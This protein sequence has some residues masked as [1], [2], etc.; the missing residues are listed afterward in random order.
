MVTWSGRG[1]TLEWLDFIRESNLTSRAGHLRGCAEAE[2]NL[3]GADKTCDFVT[4]VHNLREHLDPCSKFKV[5]AGQD[6]SRTVQGDA[7]MW[8]TMCAT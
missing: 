2:W 6:F 4:A 5:M 3:L 7:E 1:C 8:L